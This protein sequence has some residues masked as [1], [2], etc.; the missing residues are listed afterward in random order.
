MGCSTGD[1]NISYLLNTSVCVLNATIF[2]W[3]PIH[4][5]DVTETTEVWIE[6]CINFVAVRTQAVR[7]IIT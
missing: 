7:I 5:E 6:S 3:K 1:I 4:E 2:E